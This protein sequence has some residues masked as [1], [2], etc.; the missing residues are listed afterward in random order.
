LA[1]VLKLSEVD[2]RVK[3]LRSRVLRALRPLVPCK[4]T[5]NTIDWAY[6]AWT[7]DGISIESIQIEPCSRPSR[8]EPRRPLVLRLY[9]NTR[10]VETQDDPVLLKELVQWANG[11]LAPRSGKPFRMELSVL[12]DEII[13]YVPLVARLLQAGGPFGEAAELEPPMD[14][15]RFNEGENRF[16]YLWSKAAWDAMD[17]YRAER[18]ASVKA[19]R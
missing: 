12:P 5:Y 7:V 10:S 3:H 8:L 15:L 18:D 11:D 2:A 6:L 16:R 19:P 9:V 4:H 17:R 13:R 1:P 14:T